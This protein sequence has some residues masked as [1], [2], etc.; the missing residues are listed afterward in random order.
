MLHKFKIQFE[1][2]FEKASDLE[3]L[4]KA[5]DHFITCVYDVVKEIRD[6][7]VEKFGFHMVSVMHMN[8]VM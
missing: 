4:I 3:S 8:D 6:K 2:D 7:E 5:H 1:L